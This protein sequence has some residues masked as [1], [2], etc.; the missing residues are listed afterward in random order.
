VR[1][2]FSVRDSTAAD[3]ERVSDIKVRNWADAYGSI[4][5]PA[6]LAP[7]LDRDAQLA[8]LREKS[9][10]PDTLLLVAEHG[11]G[12]IIGFALTYLDYEPEPWLESLH[13]LRESRGSGLGTLLMRRTAE[14]VIA[15]G[16][17]SMR[18]GVISGNV[19]AARFYERLGGAMIGLEPLSWAPGVEHE[20]YRWADLG[21]LAQP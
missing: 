11:S 18:L 7:F 6:V 17:T 1:S 21:L 9:A 8:E 15:R 19:A 2:G 13:V 20:V 3:L 16:H 12:D 14:R 10:Q 5:E 4:L